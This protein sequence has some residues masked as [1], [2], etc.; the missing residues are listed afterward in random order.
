M[1]PLNSQVA[2]YTHHTHTRFAELLFTVEGTLQ[3]GFVDTTNKLFTQTDTMNQS[4]NAFKE[5][6]IIRHPRVGEYALGFITSSMV[7]RNKD[8][9]EI[10]YVYIPTNHFIGRSAAYRPV[11]QLHLRPIDFKM[12]STWYQTF[13][14][15]TA[16]RSSL[17]SAAMATTNPTSSKSSL[18][19]N[20]SITFKLSRANY[21]AW[22]R[23]VTTS[24]LVSEHALTLGP[25]IRFRCDEHPPFVVHA[26][27]PISA[28]CEGGVLEGV[29]LIYLLNNFT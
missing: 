27:N 9:K 3:V 25:H 5:V 10:F 20:A 24:S 29:Q 16:P 23:Q 6:A 19:L 28:G 1:Q 14:S 2:A 13:L 7:L 21:R 22:K 11:G 18:L 8:E 17:E 15:L 26:P 4:S 12:K